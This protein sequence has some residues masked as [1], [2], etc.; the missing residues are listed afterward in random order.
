[1]LAS[2]K[3]RIPSDSLGMR[4]TRDVLYVSGRVVSGD[5]L[6][7]DDSMGVEL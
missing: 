6:L 4:P 1:L 3:M 5:T 2:Q 7:Y